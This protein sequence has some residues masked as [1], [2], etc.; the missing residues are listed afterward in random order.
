MKVR[1]IM[2][3]RISTA[4]PETPV[5]EIARL[6][7]ENDCGA[8]PILEDETSGRPVGIVTD[9]DIVTRVVAVSEDPETATA[10]ECMS[11]PC[12]TVSDDSSFDDCC[13]VMEASKIRRIVVVDAEGRCC[14]V[15]AQADIA[16]READKAA[17]VVHE[18]SQPTRES[19]GG[20]RS[21]RTVS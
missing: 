1:D 15:V 5:V 14:G 2:T 20:S 19:D 18:V 10:N 12:I 3:R 16:R 17:E 9:R 11:A 6:L 13:A 7:V 21:S 4:V 8:I